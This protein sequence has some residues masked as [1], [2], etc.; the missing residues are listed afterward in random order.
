M[1]APAPPRFDSDQALYIAMNETIAK[2]AGKHTF[3]RDAQ[4]ID[5][6]RFLAGRYSD[7]NVGC[8]LNNPRRLLVQV[9][10]PNAIGAQLEGGVVVGNFTIWKKSVFGPAELEETVNNY[11][12]ILAFA[13]M[14]HEQQIRDAQAAQAA[15]AAMAAMAALPREP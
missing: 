5:E 12:N 8:I 3:F 14:A 4:P 13:K 2:V 10:V 15:Q 6:M 9:S 11:L 1:A 7:F